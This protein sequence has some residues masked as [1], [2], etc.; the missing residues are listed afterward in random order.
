MGLTVPSAFMRCYCS[1]VDL[2]AQS[3]TKSGATWEAVAADM[4]A[5]GFNRSAQACQERHWWIH[6]KDIAVATNEQAASM[7]EKAVRV[8]GWEC[9]CLQSHW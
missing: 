2:V 1:A 3:K 4:W 6:H 7:L 9:L 8:L 5:A